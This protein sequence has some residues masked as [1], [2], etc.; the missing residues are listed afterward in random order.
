[1]AQSHV[2]LEKRMDSV[3]RTI[4]ESQAKIETTLKTFSA[5]STDTWKNDMEDTINYLVDTYNLSQIAFRGKLY[6]EMDY[7]GICLNN[8]LL[9]MRKRLK[10]QGVTYRDQMAVT[11]LDVISKDKQLR[12]IFEA[13]VKKYQAV[14]AME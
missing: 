11:K 13:I 12:P 5:P 8:R 9:R 14:Y 2:Q 1:M 6:K 3:E 4:Q 7:N 10:K